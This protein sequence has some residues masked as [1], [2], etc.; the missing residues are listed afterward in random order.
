MLEACD[1]PQ[2]II[3]NTSMLGGASGIFSSFV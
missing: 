2:G 3:I 1:N